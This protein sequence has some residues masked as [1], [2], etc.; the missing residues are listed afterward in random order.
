MNPFGIVV[1]R[2]HGD[3]PVGGVIPARV[4]DEYIGVAGVVQRAR[5]QAAAMLRRA[6]R[7]RAEL[8][9]RAAEALEAA[10]I[11]GEARAEAAARAAHDATCRE[12]V[13]WLVAERE[14]E[15]RVAERLA[16]RMR[17]WVSE[18][19]ADFAG[20]AD[21]AALVAARID[22]HIRQLAGHGVFS[23]RVCPAEF[24]AVASRLP[25]D[26]RFELI[27][28]PALHAGQALL[29][30]PFVQLRIDLERHLRALLATIGAP[31]THSAATDTSIPGD[32]AA[33]APW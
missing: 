22:A 13:S 7:R 25:R 12:V 1:T 3:I 14:M 24:D 26:A 4:M 33:C 9:G 19:V 21:R 32:G 18:T 29:D 10:R 16:S 11:E 6:R 23:V 15:T 8:A 2:V 30:S 20:E 28:D 27:A 31:A 17:S 5:S